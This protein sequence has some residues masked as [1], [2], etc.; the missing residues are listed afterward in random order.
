MR[1]IF[2]KEGLRLNRKEHAIQFYTQLQS[3]KDIDSEFS[4]DILQKIKKIGKCR[5]VKDYPLSAL[6][7]VNYRIFWE[8]CLDLGIVNNPFNSQYEN[9]SVFEKKLHDIIWSYMYLKRGNQ[10]SNQEIITLF[11]KYKHCG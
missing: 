11:K 6:E 7:V 4:R 2:S 10:V 5:F 9:F 3:L 1:K 8:I